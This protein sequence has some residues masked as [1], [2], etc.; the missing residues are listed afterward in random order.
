MK[1]KSFFLKA[2]LFILISFAAPKRIFAQ[3]SVSLS[4]SPPLVE[5]M[6]KPG[7]SIVYAFEIN[8]H[9]GIDLYLKPRIVAFGPLDSEGHLSLF[10]DNPSLVP[11][12]FSLTNADIKLEQTFRLAASSSQQLVLKVSIPDNEPEKDRYF[13]FLIEQ[14]PEGEFFTPDQSKNLIKIGANLLLTISRSGLPQKQA[15]I[16]KFSAQPKILDSF[17]KANFE[18][19]I[20]NTGQAFL[21]P[22]GQIEIYHR[23]TKKKMRTLTLRPDNILVDSAREI[24]C[25]PEPCQFSSFWPGVYQA[26]L[27]FRVD[28]NEKVI[29]AKTTFYILPIKIILLM[30]IAG[31]IVTKLKAKKDNVPIDKA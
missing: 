22:E 12:Y 26:L 28:G 6:I 4:I 5:A 10:L 23:L 9:S 25:F 21:K 2:F 27:K 18:I 24:N 29:S 19:L 8:N 16:A 7:K 31:L 20:Q 13:T 1:S 11:N 3:A 17:G 14:S 30:I 15:V